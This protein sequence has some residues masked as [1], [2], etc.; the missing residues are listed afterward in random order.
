MA[1]LL[2]IAVIPVVSATYNWTENTDEWNIT[3][4]VGNG[5]SGIYSG[6]FDS[7]ENLWVVGN[8]F[9]LTGEAQGQEDSEA[10][11]AKLNSS[12]DIICNN[13]WFDVNYSANDIA[14]DNDDNVYVVGSSYTDED[15]L[16][17]GTWFIKKFNN[18]DCNEITEG[19]NR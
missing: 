1:I 5:Y 6:A 4:E 18:T 13:T 9:N 7:Y 17:N 15:S 8:A 12:G 11:L 16:P 14:I 10:L 2:I 3:F 19:W